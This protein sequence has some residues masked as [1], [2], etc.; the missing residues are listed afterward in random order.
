MQPYFFNTK[1]QFFIERKQNKYK[2]IVKSKINRSPDI[3][4]DYFP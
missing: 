2:Q 4:P 1:N 3:L